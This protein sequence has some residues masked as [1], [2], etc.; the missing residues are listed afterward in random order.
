[1]LRLEI[2][3]E[4]LWGLDTSINFQCF[5]GLRRSASAILQPLSC[6]SYVSC[7]SAVQTPTIQIWYNLAYCM[8]PVYKYIIIDYCIIYSIP[9][10]VNVK[11]PVSGSNPKPNSENRAVGIIRFTEDTSRFSC[12]HSAPRS[13]NPT[14][15][16]FTVAVGRFEAWGPGPGGPAPLPNLQ[17]YP[18]PQFLGA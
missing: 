7:H 12:Q 14:S 15:V 10:H 11:S 13:T 2:L 6:I 1:M 17:G 18:H 4:T 3:G 9:L 8:Y 16:H 5:S